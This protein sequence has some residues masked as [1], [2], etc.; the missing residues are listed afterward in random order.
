MNEKMLQILGTAKHLYPHK[1][2]TDYPR[3]VEKI[4]ELWD[5]PAIAAYFDELMLDRRG[6]RVGFQPDFLTEIFALQ[7]YYHSLQPTPPITI[8]NWPDAIELDRIEK[9]EARQSEKDKPA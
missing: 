1:L 8:H 4:T 2:D 5:S 7:N 9:K 6:D 3:I